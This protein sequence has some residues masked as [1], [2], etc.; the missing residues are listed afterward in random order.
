MEERDAVEKDARDKE[1]K[2]LSL[3]RE[4]EEMEEQMSEISRKFNNQKREYDEVLSS[5][6]DVGKSVHDL[7]KVRVLPQYTVKIV[8]L[9][10]LCVRMLKNILILNS[11]I[12]S[13]KNLL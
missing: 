10:I 1:T 6:D 2:I 13:S 5:K 12:G 9:C 7:E 4:L 8:S 3:T 11:Y